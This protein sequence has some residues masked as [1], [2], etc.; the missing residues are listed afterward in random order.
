MDP[1][2]TNGYVRVLKLSRFIN[3]DGSCHRRRFGY[4]ICVLLFLFFNPLNVSRSIEIYGFHRFRFIFIVVLLFVSIFLIDFGL[5]MTSLS[6]SLFDAGLFDLKK[7]WMLVVI[8]HMG[9]LVRE[10]ILLTVCSFV[11][12]PTLFGVCKHSRIIF[13]YNL[14]SCPYGFVGLCSWLMIFVKID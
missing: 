2:V 14:V 3:D 13:F 9:L 12:F 4:T 8:Y 7:S 6:L 5:T 11:S 10:F 1:A